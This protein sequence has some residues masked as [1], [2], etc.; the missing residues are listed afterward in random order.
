MFRR[1]FAPMLISG[2]ISFASTASAVE[3][4]WDE[5]VSRIRTSIETKDYQGAKNVW[6]VLV[7]DYPDHDVLFELDMRFTVG[8]IVD[9]SSL[10]SALAYRNPGLLFETKTQRAMQWS[11][12][13]TQLDALDYYVAEH[14]GD[15]KAP[16]SQRGT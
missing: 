6:V 5:G 13:Q 16:L 12:F 1:S 2:I 14:A 8:D 9:A 3:L 7:R 11:I 10:L 15:D 4:T